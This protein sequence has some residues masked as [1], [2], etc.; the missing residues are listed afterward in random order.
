MDQAIKSYC[1]VKAKKNRKLNELKQLLI[2]E[3]D[4]FGQPALGC[5]SRLLDD[6]EYYAYLDNLVNPKIELNNVMII[7]DSEDEIEGET[8]STK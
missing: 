2:A 6:G 8:K 4:R 1:F 7:R 3:A 5:M